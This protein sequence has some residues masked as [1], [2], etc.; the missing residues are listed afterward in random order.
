ME[1]TLIKVGLPVK[2]GWGDCPATGFVRPAFVD[3][4]HGGWYKSQLMR[5]NLRK[6]WACP[7]HAQKRKEYDEWFYD[8]YRTPEPPEK[9]EE[10]LDEL[11]KILD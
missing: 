4:T 2:C 11:Y 7:E 5:F 8:R 10:S 9:P 3:P 6:R 1:E